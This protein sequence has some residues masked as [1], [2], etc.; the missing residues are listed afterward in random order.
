MADISKIKLLNGITYTLKD[1]QVRTELT[2]FTDSFTAN[3]S[4]LAGKISNLAKVATS[5]SYNDLIDKP[6][7][8]NFYAQKNVPTDMKVGEFWFVVEDK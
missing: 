8:P 1:S 6:K 5:G 4:T 2:K 7:I 3:L